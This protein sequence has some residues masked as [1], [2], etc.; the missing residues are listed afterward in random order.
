M[1]NTWITDMCHLPPPTQPL[2]AELTPARRLADSLGASVSAASEAPSA[3]RLSLRCAAA[4]GQGVARARRQV[5]LRVQDVAAQI[6]GRCSACDDN[7]CI[8]HTRHEQR[9]FERSV[10]PGKGQP[11]PA[12][13]G[14]DAVHKNAGP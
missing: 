3:L 4:S 12:L 2:S 11:V 13:T 1:A 8:T 14:A 5:L 10:K 6:A 7:G 9:P